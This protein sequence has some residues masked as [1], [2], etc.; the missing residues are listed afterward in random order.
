MDFE[1]DLQSFTSLFRE[2]GK[3]LI[4]LGIAII[5]KCN[6]QMY[7]LLLQVLKCI[8]H[9]TKNG[10]SWGVIFSLCSATPWARSGRKRA[11]QGA[12]RGQAVLL[13]QQHHHQPAACLDRRWSPPPSP[14][15]PLPF[16]RARRWRRCQRLWS[17]CCGIRSPILLLWSP[18]FV[19][20]LQIG[21][22]II[23]FS[24]WSNQV[25]NCLLRLSTLITN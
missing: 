23:Q 13:Q 18:V 25:V 10:K 11:D 4:S 5:K 7:V 22:H 1:V 2:W 9:K 14:P 24:K 20:W 16:P 15:S 19:L 21:E 3:I 12:R 8:L 17:S 6:H